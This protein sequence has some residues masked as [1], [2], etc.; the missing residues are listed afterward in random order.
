MQENPKRQRFQLSIATVMLLIAIVAISAA[1][2]TDHS[3][4]MQQLRARDIQIKVFSLQNA[5]VATTAAALKEQFPDSKWEPTRISIDGRT[6]GLIVSA[7]SDTLDK[8]E[9]LLMRMDR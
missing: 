3:R 1:W 4:L 5:D 8:I 6:N 2:W 7:P 9:A